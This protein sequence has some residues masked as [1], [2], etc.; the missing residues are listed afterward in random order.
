METVVRTITTKL[1]PCGKLAINFDE[2][3]QR[4]EAAP[5]QRVAQHF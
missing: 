4:D 5:F 1:G 3:A 2:A